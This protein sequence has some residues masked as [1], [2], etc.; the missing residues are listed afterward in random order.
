[1]NE[2]VLIQ[3]ESIIMYFVC[4]ILSII[5]ISLTFYLFRLTEKQKNL[6]ITESNFFINT[7]NKYL[8][9]P[10]DYIATII[11]NQSLLY[12]IYH[13]FNIRYLYFVSGMLVLVIIIH[14]MSIKMVK[15]YKEE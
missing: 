7:I 6:E 12:L 2:L 13:F 9:F 4:M 8:K 14:Y 10:F 15:K 1:M 11:F 5:D 3:N